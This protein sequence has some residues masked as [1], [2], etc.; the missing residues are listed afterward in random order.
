GRLRGIVS[1]PVEITPPPE[2]VR[3]EHDVEVAVRD[4]TIL[5]VNV[6]RPEGDGSYPVIMCAHPYGKDGLPERGPFGY[7]PPTQYRV[8]RQPKPVTWSAWTTWESPDPAYWVPRG[9]AVVNC[10]LRG[11]GTS[12][13]RGNLLTDDEAQDIYD[14]IEWAGT[15]PWSNGKVG[16]NGVSYLAI[17]QYKAAALRPPHLAAICPWEGFS[18]VYRDFAR[19]GGI[20]EDGFMPRW[21]SGIKRGGRPSE[22]VREEQIARP[23]LDQWWRARTPELG[24]I[25][26]PLL[27]CASFSDQQLHSRG[28]FRTFERVSSPHRWLYTHRGGKW[29]EYYSDGALAFQSRF[30]DHFLKGEENAMLEVSPVR[31]EVREDRDTIHEVRSEEAWP[32]SRTRWTDLYLR[33]D[34]RLTDAPATEADAVSFELS[35]GRASFT[36]YVPEDLEITGPMALRL[37][38]E[39]RG[40]EDVYLF[41]GVQKLRAGRVVPFEG[42]YGYGFDRVT[43]GWLKA[44][45][46][47]LDSGRSSPWRPAHTYDEFQ[48]LK[49]GEVV[50]VDISLLPS[51]TFFRRGEQIRL[52]VQGRWFSS[53]SP[54]LGQ[55]P[56]A[57]ERGPQGT[58]VLHMGGE[59]SARL[60]IPVIPAQE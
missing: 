38:V 33:A 50:A 57:Y 1:P 23:L 4:G 43:T 47:K 5:R 15:Q 12:G 32:L 54:L 7:R 39:V 8:I 25:E 55:F 56:A 11:F 46:R 51:A 20:R 28:S 31:L 53:R 34:G 48:P 40:A 29:A 3:F 16:M 41:V 27:V 60:R 26:V 2:G 36:W 49:P 13:G 10:D 44:S 14:L 30:F 17:S 18:D 35:S 24:R 52:D 22:D 9:Y 19:P 37:S 58:C 59:H 42:S 6:Y 45:L 21:S